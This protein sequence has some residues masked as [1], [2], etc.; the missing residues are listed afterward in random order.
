MVFKNPENQC[1]KKTNVKSAH[2]QI[3]T[4]HNKWEPDID[5]NIYPILAIAKRRACLATNLCK[6]MLDYVET[7]KEGL[8]ADVYDRVKDFLTDTG[9]EYKKFVDG[10]NLSFMETQ[11]FVKNNCSDL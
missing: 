5:K 11:K 10:L 8:E 4:G 7:I 6:N 3:H 1:I 2:S 9:K